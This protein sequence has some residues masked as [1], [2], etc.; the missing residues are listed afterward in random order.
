MLPAEAPGWKEVGVVVS[1]SIS[2][3]S[4]AAAPRFTRRA[5]RETKPVGGGAAAEAAS[6]WGGKKCRLP[7]TIGR[8]M[9]G[10]GAGGV[11]AR[12]TKQSSR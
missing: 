11:S 12:K 10:D 4:T 1:I 7:F 8:G 2:I 5:A 9:G 6:G 3:V